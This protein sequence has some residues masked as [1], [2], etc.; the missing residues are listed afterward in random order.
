MHLLYCDESNLDENAGDF[1]IYGG[2]MV[3]ADAAA[4]LSAEIE[5]IRTTAGIDRNFKLKFNPKPEGMSHID[6]RDV[7]QA[8]LQ[9][10]AKHD[11]ALLTYAILH[12]ISSSPDEARRF[13]INTVC[14]HFD[15]CLRA[16]KSKGLVL[17]DRFNDAGNAIDA[18]LTEKFAIGVRFPP[19]DKEYR[20]THVLGLHYTAVGQSHFT[21]LIDIALG[22]LRYAVN[23]HT[24]DQVAQVGS[25]HALLALLSPLFVRA[26]G[27][28]QVSEFGM[29]LSPKVIKSA[30][31]RARYQALKDFL[32]EGGVNL[33]QKISE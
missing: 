12:D 30:K 18:H 29:L 21:S 9:A 26:N 11:V 15:C 25:A 31:Y 10:A 16:L 33:Q 32:S 20:L 3:S 13:G 4:S 8:I 1:L 5:K 28:Q 23:V 14:Y 22:S 19:D 7:K 24:R 6:Y 17:I 27:T 2:V